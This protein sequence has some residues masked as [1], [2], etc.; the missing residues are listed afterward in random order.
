MSGMHIE[1]ILRAKTNKIASSS[2]RAVCSDPNLDPFMNKFNMG[3]ACLN[4]VTT[5]TCIMF[6]R[7]K[8]NLKRPFRSF[9]PVVRMLVW[10]CLH[11]VL[12]VFLTKT[13]SPKIKFNAFWKSSFPV[14]PARPLLE[15]L[16]EPAMKEKRKP[17]MEQ[18]IMHKTPQTILEISELCAE[19]CFLLQWQWLE[20]SWIFRLSHCI[21]CRHVIHQEIYMHHLFWPFT[22]G[23]LQNISKACWRLMFPCQGNA[24]N[25]HWHSCFFGDRMPLS[26]SLTKKTS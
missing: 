17:I 12:H 20:F 24:W 26:E 25:P 1:R 23:T 10:F 19:V 2:L 5:C 7:N 14:A 18:N 13:H 4:K 16:L 6:P 15:W 9:S 3:Y 11:H 8:K 21:S 22:C